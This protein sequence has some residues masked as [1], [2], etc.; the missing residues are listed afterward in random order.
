MVTMLGG[1]F[2]NPVA[3][4]TLAG[5]ADYTF[6]LELESEGLRVDAAELTGE[7]IVFGTL[8]RKLRDDDQWSLLD[9]MGLSALPNAQ[10]MIDSLENVKDLEGSVVR[11]PAAVLKP[12]AIYR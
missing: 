9:A 8:E 10:E 4:A 1:L 11:P 2:K 3:L 5:A 6:I 7:M 12:I